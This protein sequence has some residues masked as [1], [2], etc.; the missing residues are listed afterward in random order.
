MNEI[1]EQGIMLLD[2][3]AIKYNNS[4]VF[5]QVCKTKKN[6]VTL[7]ELASK[8]YLD[9][10]MLDPAMVAS[11][12]PIIIKKN[13]TFTKSTFEVKPI[14]WEKDYWLPIEFNGFVYYAVP[15]KDYRNKVWTVLPEKEETEEIGLA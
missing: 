3:Y 13:N 5:F 11:K 8:P 6:S 7:I 1:N 10:I 12:K 2:V 15:L 4:M 9:G 14:K